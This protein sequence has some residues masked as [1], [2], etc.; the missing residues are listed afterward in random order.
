LFGLL[1]GKAK[2]IFLQRRKPKMTY[3][4]EDKDLLTLKL[5]S[6]S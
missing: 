3:I 4:T 6:P 1:G 2:Q 5:L